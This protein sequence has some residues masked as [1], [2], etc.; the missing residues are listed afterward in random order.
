MT[1]NPSEVTQ[2]GLALLCD[3][4]GTV[5]EVVRDDLGVTSGRVPIGSLPLLVDRGSLWK[6]LDFLVEVRSQGRALHR[7]LNATHLGRLT[8]LYLAGF[9]SGENLIIVGAETSD[10]ALRIYDELAQRYGGAPH[11]KEDIHLA[12]QERVRDGALFDSIAV[13][14]NEL[15]NMQRELSRKAVELERLNDRMATLL[16]M[17][18]EILSNLEL[19]PLLD[20]VLQ[21][22][23]SVVEYSSAS[24]LTVSE[25]IVQWHAYSGPDLRTESS[26]VRL[27]PSQIPWVE[28]MLETQR[29]FSIGDLRSEPGMLE[30]LESSAYLPMSAIFGRARSAICL[31]LVARSKVIGILALLHDEPQRFGPDTLGFVETFANQ[32]AIAIH[33]ARL[34][35]QAQQAAVLSERARLARELHDSVA[36]A[37]YTI[38]L[39]SDATLL[40]LSSGRTDALGDNITQISNLVREAM[41]E[42]RVLTFELRPSVLE[43]EGLI[44]ALRSRLDAVEDRSG[45]ETALEVQGEGRLPVSAEAEIYRVAQEAL[46]NVIKHAKARQVTIGVTFTDDRFLLTIED[47]G[48][49]FDS[50]EAERVGGFGMLTMRE[51]VQQIGGSLEIESKV[52]RGTIVRVEVQR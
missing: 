17:S 20:L 45:L 33:N 32:V 7:Q 2:S 18:H 50:R 43:E 30:Y 46:N 11:P 19:R 16:S 23:N 10:G 51:R 37:L 9:V 48:V 34:F 12:E 49:G 35:D 52:G 1:E 38:T 27:S 28:E 21:E 39:Y 13:L 47:D 31:P 42:M 44:G 40:A 22:L 36:Q 29:G 4:H 3:I 41:S 5:L 26:L 24:I 15:L 6:A 8:P 25:G 14:Y